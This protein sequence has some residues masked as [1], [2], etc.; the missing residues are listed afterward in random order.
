MRNLAP[1]LIAVALCSCTKRTTPTNEAAAASVNNLVAVIA[2]QN[3]RAARAE[4]NKRPIAL[5]EQAAMDAH[6]DRNES[7]F[8]FYVRTCM[9]AHGY[10]VDGGDCGATDSGLDPVC[11][12]PSGP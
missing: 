10:R 8:N 7:D 4:K 11:Y 5:C 12:L 3:A 2:D 9:V 1:L 6:R